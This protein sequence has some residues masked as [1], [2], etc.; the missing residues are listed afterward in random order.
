MVSTNTGT[1]LA[2]A[3]VLATCAM[4]AS[5]REVKVFQHDN[6]VVAVKIAAPVQTGGVGWQKIFNVAVPK[7]QN[8][9]AIDGCPDDA[10]VP[11]GNSFSPNTAAKNGL[12]LIAS[13]HPNADPQKWQWEIHWPVGAPTGARI[14]FNIYCATP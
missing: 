7:G 12:Q 6:G 13:F 2:L 14:Y 4:S 1:R 11:V 5:A 10:K 3:S 8:L 9:I